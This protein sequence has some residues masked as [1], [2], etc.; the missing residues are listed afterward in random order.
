VQGLTTASS[1]ASSAT[2]ISASN[3]VANTTT[4]A[5][6]VDGT[7]QAP[8]N[9]LSSENVAVANRGASDAQS[10]AAW[11]VAAGAVGSPSGVTAP[12]VAGAAP[13][14]NS[15]TATGLQAQ[16]TFSSSTSTTAISAGG[17]ANTAPIT[18]DPGQQLVS[19]ANRGTA[20]AT[21]GAACAAAAACS[22]ATTG[23]TGLAGASQSASGAAD[24]RG[25]EA[26]NQVTTDATVVVR[27]RGQNF[28]PISVLIDSIAQIFNLG[29]GQST[30]GDSTTSG[31]GVSSASLANQASASSGSALAAGAVVQNRIDMRSSADV[32]VEGD[33]YS[34]ITVVLDMA[35]NL[36]NWGIGLAR[37]GDAQAGSGASPT[38]QSATSGAAS[39]RGLQVFNLV[40]MWADATVDVEG[41]NYAPITVDVHFRSNIDNRGLAVAQSGNVAAGSSA[42]ASPVQLP[43]DRSA[44]SAAASSAVSAGGSNQART[45]AI[46]GNALAISNSASSSISSDQLASANGGNAISGTTITNLL[47]SVPSSNWN[48]T[49]D[50]NLAPTL[51]LDAQDGLNSRSGSSTAVGLHSDLS[52]SNAQLVACT[53]PQI[54]CTAQNSANLSASVADSPTNLAS[55]AGD[56]TR[57]GPHDPG[58]SA[59]VQGAFVNATPTPT[60]TTSVSTNTGSSPVSSDG[61][62]GGRRASVPPQT[63]SHTIVS[64]V[65]TTPDVSASGHVVVV[66]LWDRWPGRRLPPMPDPTAQ[67]A[68]HTTVEASL[69]AWPGTDELPLPDVHIA[70]QTGSGQPAGRANVAGRRGV[71]ASLDGQAEADDQ[72][73]E[74]LAVFEVDPWSVWPAIDDLPTPGQTAL[75]PGVASVQTDTLP[76]EAAPAAQD[77][78][79][80]VDLTPVALLLAAVG[81]VAAGV[82]RWRVPLLALVT[83]WHNQLA[84]GAWL[85]SVRR[86]S[87]QR[88]SRAQAFLRMTVG[89][90]RLW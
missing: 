77:G 86:L 47:R 66:D 85:T 5:V 39:A 11:A 89:I 63:V 81:A 49:T 62:S 69:D 52:Q 29:V 50:A 32:Q 15:A 42:S 40:S 12:I 37:S 43:A 28:A 45:S 24:A 20:T 33:N 78:A 76:D 30:S 53:N 1:G 22:S 16:N 3:T 83:T 70:P 38:G 55:E 59:V 73:I 9:L 57:P 68:T 74:L 64:N 46:G 71:A 36:V 10:G 56:G 13:T 48:P 82:W 19:V 54:G 17:A 14:S 27:V 7:S 2:G 25:L 67:N 90:L 26:R 31:W 41:D 44:S 88:L 8:V 61:G 84:A 51:P 79:G 72:P 58:T 6:Q 65:S 18:I 23:T 21:S 60:P 87:G 34:P 75:S 4:T 80:P 35:A